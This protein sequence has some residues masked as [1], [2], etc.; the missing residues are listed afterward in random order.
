MFRGW[1][2]IWLDPQFST[3]NIEGYLDAIRCPTLVIQGEDDQ[4]GTVAH[5]DAIQR[6]VP[7]AQKLIMSNCGHSPHRDQPE[8][9]L[10]AISKFV[11]ALT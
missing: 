3:W 1:T 10:A 4:Y 11:A 9:T 2:D 6:R 7:G 5:V 8:L